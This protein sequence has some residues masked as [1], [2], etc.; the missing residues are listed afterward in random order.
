MHSDGSSSMNHTRDRRTYR[1]DCDLAYELD[2]ACD[3]VFMI[4]AQGPQAGQT[5]LDETL[6]IEPQVAHRVNEDPASGSRRLR[7]RADKGSLA[8]RYQALVERERAFIDTGATPSPIDQLPDDVLQ[9]LLPTRYCDSDQL[10]TVARQLFGDVTPGWQQVRAI[11][12]WIADN[13]EYRLGSSTPSTTACDVVVRRAGACRD[14]A[15][16]GASFCR[17]LNIPARLVSGYVRFSDASPGFHAVFEAYLGG[18][19]STFEATRLAPI[20]ELIRIA[21]GRDAGD[22]AF[23]TIYGPAR[24]THIRPRVL[25]W[26]AAVGDV[27]R[28]SGRASD[29]ACSAAAAS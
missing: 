11:A 4:H 13:I 17:A 27:L 28:G 6:H 16:L 10:T 25:A 14:F 8:I 12:D 22:V 24:S 18:R 26:P 3:F 29:G 21:S 9:Y 5:I 23:A 15:H 20:G 7:L 2:D 19:W 1:I